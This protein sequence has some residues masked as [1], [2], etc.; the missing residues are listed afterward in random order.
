MLCNAAD[1]RT[2]AY[3]AGISALLVAQ[4]LLSEIEPLLVLASCVMAISVPIMAHNHNHAPMWRSRWLNRLT[5]YWL[6]LFYGMPAFVW[7]PTHNMN[8]HRY[9][10]GARDRSSTWQLGERNDLATLITYPLVSGIRQMVLIRDFLAE[11]WASKRRRAWFYI[12]QIALLVAYVALALA[13]DWQK[14]LLTIVLPQQIALTS[15]LVFNYLQHVHADER[16]ELDH[17]RN[18]TGRLLNG[19]LFNS[20]FHTVHHSNAGLH[21]S[22]TPAAHAAI[23]SAMHPSLLQPS[24]ARFLLR[25]YVLGCF[26]GKWRTEPLGRVE[27]TGQNGVDGVSA[28]D[29]EMASARR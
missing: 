14:A 6:T 7:V 23:A 16:S 11:R 18:F 12:S 4:W 10:N 21:W 15:V 9:L 17:S 29:G 3:F 1:V 26:D 22:E 8:H 28:S 2:V 13:L 25:T 19:F 24:L 5:D 20:G 27:S